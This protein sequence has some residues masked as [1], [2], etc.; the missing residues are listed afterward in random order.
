MDYMKAKNSHFNGISQLGQI[1][2]TRDATV[3]FN[4]EARVS[5]LAIS[6]DGLFSV[7][8][9]GDGVVCLS[10]NLVDKGNDSLIFWKAEGKVTGTIISNNLIFILDEMFGLNCL[11]TELDVIWNLEID[12]GGFEFKEL[13]QSFAI[14]D[15]LGRLHITSKDGTI[16]SIVED[17]SS[18][19]KIEVFSEN[20]ITAHENGEVRVF[21]GSKT[22]WK[23][24]KRGEIGESI[25]HI[26]GV[27]GNKLLIGREGYAL[28]P[29]EEEALEIEI[30]DFMNDNLI[31]RKDVE[32]RLISST[33]SDTGLILGFSSGEIL[34]LKEGSDGDLEKEMK[35]IAECGYP[36]K[37]LKFNSKQIIFSAWFFIFGVLENGQIWKVEHKG[38]P[39][40]IVIS[41]DGNICLF[42]GEDQNDWTSAEP[43]GLVSL[44]GDLIEKEE[45]ELPLWFSQD[46][47]LMTQYSDDIYSEEEISSHLSQEEMDDLSN[48]Q[49]NN[50]K[51]SIDDLIGAL[52]IP[53][54]DESKSTISGTL[55]IDTEELLSQ[56]DDE[57]EKIAM[58]P[59]QSIIDELNSTV[60]EI[61]LPIANAGD[62]QRIVSDDGK[63]A[64]V[65]LDATSSFDPQGRIRQWSWVDE[66][67][68]EISNLAKLNVRLN[69]GTFRFE[70]RVCDSDG[71]WSTDTLLVR[72]LKEA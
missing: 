44:N 10:K 15:S 69:I 8:S 60:E 38:I 72:I 25:T 12:G 28:V 71:N 49:F 41:E 55:D 6:K 39:E 54:I 24:P 30:W 14:V 32:S 36:I 45:S 19:S 35:I 70:L 56:L 67:G 62:D 48:S 5:T 21:D 20:I 31:S 13:S 18:I 51:E 1:M 61:Q 53:S 47:N 17:Y 3:A 4:P 42:A 43:I 16:T 27:S 9:E 63:T 64:I 50:L 40:L 11:N 22:I 34:E 68:K 57:I 52:E 65:N 46:R 29:G 2:L 33:N 66:S 7:W 37:T 58:L 59:D 23:R 26:G